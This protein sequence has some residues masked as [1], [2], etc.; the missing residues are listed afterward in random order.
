MTSD[1]QLER[2]TLV[3]DIGG[4]S[5]E[6]VVAGPAGVL[7]RYSIDIGSVRLTERFLRGDPPSAGSSGPAPGMS[8]P[9]SRRI[10]SST[11]IGVAGTIT[12]LAAIE[13][14]MAE[15]DRDGSTATA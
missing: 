8:R 12:S 3:L 5:T 10:S 6:L 9:R 15:Y 13:L 11:A 1:R 14:G 4:G 2:P 7:S